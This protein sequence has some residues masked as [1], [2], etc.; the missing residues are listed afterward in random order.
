MI[1]PRCKATIADTSKFCPECGQALRAIAIPDQR[2]RITRPAAPQR[3][4]I[5]ADFRV[6]ED[7]WREDRSSGDETHYHYHDHL[8]IHEAPRYI[9]PTATPRIPRGGIDIHV[10]E[11]DRGTNVTISGPNGE[12]LTKVTTGSSK[13][14]FLH[15]APGLWTVHYRHLSATVS[16]SEWGTTTAHLATTC[17]AHMCIHPCPKASSTG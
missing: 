12:Q 15:L 3:N 2:T 7:D 17:L 4:D 6:V 8:H 9:Q 1:C 13:V 16:V 11:L 5:D 10:P 14:W